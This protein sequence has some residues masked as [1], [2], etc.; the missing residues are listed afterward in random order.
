MAKHAPRFLKLVD[1]AKKHVRE[2]TVAD[3][4]S[5]LDRGE[6]FH[7]VDVREESEWARDG[8]IVFTSSTNPGAP[9]LRRVWRAT[10]QRGSGEWVGK[11]GKK[12]L[13]S[14]DFLPVKRLALGG[15]WRA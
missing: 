4:K 5:K 3:V 6:K 15:A 7:L 2:C 8:C 10:P 9:H 13:R 12:I 14:R 1:E 11:T